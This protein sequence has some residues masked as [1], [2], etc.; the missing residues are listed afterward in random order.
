MALYER[1]YDKPEEEERAWLERM[2]REASE[3]LSVPPDRIVLKT[4]RRQRGNDQYGRIS[5]AGREIEV[6]EGGLSFRVNLTDYLDTGLFLDHRGTRCRAKADAPGRR[7]LN[8]FCYTGSFS[9]YSASGGA[10]SVDSVDLSKTYLAWAERN[11]TLNGFTGPA[12]RYIRKDASAFLMEALE[13]GGEYGL[14]I[15]DP[16]TFSNSKR[17]D[18]PLDISEDWPELVGKCLAVL[19]PGGVLWFST[20]ARRFRFDEAL[21]PG[22]RIA[23]M[24]RATTPPDFEGSKPHRCWRLEKP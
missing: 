2:R 18:E 21:F 12:Y 5:R 4:R 19:S 1:P 13:K 10:A 7:V 20:N 16:P 6:R 8:L 24:T 14:V 17:M 23:D 22:V 11:M 9:V 15:L 3:V